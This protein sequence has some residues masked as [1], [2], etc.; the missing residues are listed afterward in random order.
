MTSPPSPEITVGCR[1]RLVALPDFVKTADPM[2]M[3]RPPTVLILG[4]EGLV[5]ERRSHNTWVI[6]FEDKS[7]LLSPSYLEVIT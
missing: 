7:Y 5:M 1:V 2:P 3:L 6:R 4:A